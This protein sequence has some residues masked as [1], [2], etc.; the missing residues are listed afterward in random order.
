MKYCVNCGTELEDDATVCPNCS[1]E[2][3]LAPA[4]NEPPKEEFAT[5]PITI[6]TVLGLVGLGSAN[7]WVPLIMSI[8]GIIY[9]VKE[10]KLTGKKLGL[11]LN[12]IVL[13]LTC[14]G[15]VGFIAY[16]VFYF[17]FLFGALA[18]GGAFG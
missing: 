13:V 12:I 3:V 14:I 5:L 11:I 18:G 1:Q 4:Q 17:L 16:F 10:K 8:I 6:S 15:I 7:F 9:G 2:T